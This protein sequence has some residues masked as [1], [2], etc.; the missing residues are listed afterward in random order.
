VQ[1]TEQINRTQAGHVRPVG[2]LP[3][4]NM[5]AGK[6][7]ENVY[8]DRVITPLGRFSYPSVFERAKAME[9]GKE[10]KYE[11][12]LLIPKKSDISA[13]KD[14]IDKVG[15]EAFGKKWDGDANSPKPRIKDGDALAARLERED[16]PK[17][18]AVYRGH[19]VVRTQSG[20]RPGVVGPDRQPIEDKDE[21]Y[22]GCWG[23]LSVTPGSYTQ[24][25]NWGVTLYLNNVQK[26]RDDEPF[27]G[28]GIKAEDEFQDFSDAASSN[29]DL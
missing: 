7:S 9:D 3:W 27:G 18:A 24:L 6:K 21:V 15:K 5:A 23:R 25:G 13:L 4:R 12:T 26:V 1:A 22:G 28:D 10:G 8:G 20:K 2:T 14:A 19:W 16:K 17:A 11:V 29:D